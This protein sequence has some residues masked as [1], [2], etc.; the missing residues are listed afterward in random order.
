MKIGQEII[1][2]SSLLFV[3]TMSNGQYTLDRESFKTLIK[4]IR[5]PGVKEQADSYVFKG[6]PVSYQIENIRVSFVTADDIK[7]VPGPKNSFS[8]TVIGL[9]GRIDGAFLAQQL[10]KNTFSV[11]GSI[12]GATAAIFSAVQLEATGFFTII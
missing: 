12:R 2:L 10:K 4:K 9:K 1:R 5:F 11:V 3:C 6:N 7:V 8:I